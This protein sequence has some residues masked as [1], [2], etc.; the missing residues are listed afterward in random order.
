[1]DVAFGGLRAKRYAAAVASLVGLLGVSYASSAR[2]EAGALSC[3]FLDA[4]EVFPGAP[5]CPDVG[6]VV[7][8][9]DPYDY[10]DE[11]N[12]NV[13]LYDNEYERDEYVDISGLDAEGSILVLIGTSNIE[14][15]FGVRPD[16]VVDSPFPLLP[17]GGTIQGCSDWSYGAGGRLRFNSC[18]GRAIRWN[19]RTSGELVEPEPVN[20]LGEV[21]TLSG[22]RSVFTTDDGGVADGGSVDASVAP[23]PLC[24][25]IE[26]PPTTTI[27][28]PTTTPNDTPSDP[29]TPTPTSTAT[30]T[31]P[32]TSDDEGGADDTASDDTISDPNGGA[33][34]PSSDAATNGNAD[35]A[36]RGNADGA[37]PNSTQSPGSDDGSAS[38]EADAR[39]PANDAGDPVIDEGVTARGVDAESNSGCGCR[40]GSSG[41]GTSPLAALLLLIVG[42]ARRRRG[43]TS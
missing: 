21:G 9:V 12:N 23:A 35:D 11:F 29:N 2:A 8:R 38:D 30:D 42:L 4:V 15:Y 25:Q 36:T 14:E 27:P 10:V 7:I 39:E 32:S 31:T 5:G 41:P 1:M 16:F 20:S 22:C 26:P 13:E 18:E 3:V 40:V 43:V 33:E 28:T 34:E 24:E 37:E 19:N 17:E 6:Y